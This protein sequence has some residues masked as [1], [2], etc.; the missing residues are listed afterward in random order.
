[1]PKF[2][3]SDRVKKTS[4]YPYDGVVV[5]VFLTL[6]GEWRY[7][8]EHEACVGMLHIFNGSQLDFRA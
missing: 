1:M 5:A 2:Q 4:G 8:V 3:I 6:A 7:V